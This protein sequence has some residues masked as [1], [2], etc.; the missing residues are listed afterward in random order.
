MGKPR[1]VKNDVLTALYLE[2]SI[3]DRST[4]SKDRFMQCHIERG[5]GTVLDSAIREPLCIYESLECRS[6]LG[7]LIASLETL[8]T[9]INLHIHPSSSLLDLEILDNL[10]RGTTGHS[11][12]KM[13]QR[14]TE[15]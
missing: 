9:K 13:L 2:D 4:A 12:L 10:N 11:L 15:P 5:R 6:L 7:A 8:K 3:T 1:A 14:I